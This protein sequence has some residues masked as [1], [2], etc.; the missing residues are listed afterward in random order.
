MNTIG[1]IVTATV[2]AF[3]GC[4]SMRNKPTLTLTPALVA[5]MGVVR[6]LGELQKDGEISKQAHDILVS[7]TDEQNVAVREAQL[8][9]LVASGTITDEMMSN[10]KTAIEVANNVATDII[11]SQRESD[12]LEESN[13]MGQ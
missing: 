5:R 12:A 3:T 9:S 4:Q 2:L 1:K 6:Y 11:N 7:I 10:I 8:A 13:T